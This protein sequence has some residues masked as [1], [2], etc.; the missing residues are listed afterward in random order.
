MTSPMTG[1][2]IHRR[3][4]FNNYWF[5]TGTP[6]FLLELIMKSK[7]NL[8]VSLNNPVS[9]SFFNVFEINDLDPLVLLHQ[10]GYLTIDRAEQR[11]IPFTTRT[12]KEYYL[13]FPNQEVEESFN[14]SLLA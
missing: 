5:T 6:S 12:I 11:T 4:E 13:R 2:R 7:L 10:T 3:F 9:G 14:D 1:S 8:S